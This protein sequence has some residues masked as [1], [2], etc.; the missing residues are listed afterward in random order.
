MS[1]CQRSLYEDY[2]EDIR[3]L[4]E[5]IQYLK[6]QVELDHKILLKYIVLLESKKNENRNCID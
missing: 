1:N 4:K 2:D 5:D 3:K 6:E